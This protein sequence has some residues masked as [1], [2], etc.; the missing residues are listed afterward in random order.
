[1]APS[2]FPLTLWSLTAAAALW[3]PA[4]AQ[5]TPSESA[6]ASAP[7]AAAPPSTTTAPEKPRARQELFAKLTLQD[8]K[9]RSAKE[10]RV[11]I[12]ALTA[13]WCTPCKIMDQTT[14]RDPALADWARDHALLISLDV[15]QS[16]EARALNAKA[17]PALVAFRDGS[18][19]DRVLGYRSAAQ[20]LD[21]AKGVARGERHSE[22]ALKL[23]KE[24]TTDKRHAEPLELV[25]MI[26]AAVDAREF[27]LAV[28]A[29]QLLWAQAD[30]MD[31][32]ALEARSQSIALIALV[33][34]QHAQSHP[35]L[36]TL[37][38]AQLDA[39]DHAADPL[40][41]RP[42][43]HLTDWILLNEALEDLDRTETWVAQRARAENGR[44]VLDRIEATLAPLLT[45]RERWDALVHAVGEPII[46]ARLQTKMVK[47]RIAMPGSTLDKDQKAEMVEFY[48]EEMRHQAA[49][50]AAALVAADRAADA[51]RVMTE[52]IDLDKSGRALHTAAAAAL[53][54][55]R[56]DPI[57]KQWLDQAQA[58]G[59]D[60]ASLRQ[61]LGA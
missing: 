43:A 39:F 57:V 48:M 33:W 5:P 3:S 1:M 59:I 15:D 10:N 38:D 9:T 37:R 40:E 23:L 34:R 32:E 31:S 28:R 49:G 17:L 41:P 36:T 7:P 54:R 61:K 53:A 27:D 11:L 18:E 14:W 26:S 8:A 35:P 44:A 21:W 45:Q 50:Y 29:L 55:D 42:L 6:P 52:I 30:G 12:V 22:Q 13:E 19:F 58:R 2:A 60:V 51:D 47:M 25:E 56:K 46:W 4:L 24:V 16:D 20:V